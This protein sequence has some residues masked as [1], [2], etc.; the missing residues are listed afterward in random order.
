MKP[1]VR[2]KSHLNFFDLFPVPPFLAMPAVGFDISDHAVR[3]IELLKTR[4]GMELG[5]FVSRALP[6]GVVAEGIIQNKKALA[7]I[8]RDI[9]KEY[10]LKFIHASLPVEQ[11]YLFKMEIPGSGSGN[12]HEDIRSIIE[13]KLEE[14]VPIAPEEAMFDYVMLKDDKEKRNL[15]VGVTVVPREVVHDY[16]SVFRSAGLIPLS[17]EVEAAAIARAVIP[18]SDMSTAMIVDFGAIKTG[19]SVVSQGVVQFTTVVEI[20]S[21]VLTAALERSFSITTEEAEA[22]KKEKGFVQTRKNKAVFDA[23]INTISAL[24]DEINRYIVYWNTHENRDKDMDK[25]ITRIIFCGGGANLLGLTD[26]MATSLAMKVAL[27]DVWINTDI[28]NHSV[29]DIHFNDALSYVTAIG[30]TLRNP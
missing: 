6:R 2:T 30:L 12:A 15:A 21:N 28:L 16:L 10:Q 29:P 26:Y 23:L 7:D 22:M 20:G 11:T 18:L 14:S 13:F 8:L 4:R 25:P 9:Q 24:K 5:K 17:F 3:F 1:R 19:I 27:A